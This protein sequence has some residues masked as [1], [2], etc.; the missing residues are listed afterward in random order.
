[1]LNQRG[2]LT[3]CPSSDT[4]WTWSGQALCSAT[5]KDR[6]VEGKAPQRELQQIK[7]PIRVLYGR[8]IK[9][10]DWEGDT[11]VFVVK[12]ALQKMSAAV[13]ASKNSTH[14]KAQLD[15]AS[16]NTWGI[17]DENPLQGLFT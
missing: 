17:K 14:R 10:E 5:L 3:G 16:W 8:I 13:T 4:A 2:V 11:A 15:V 6:D 9:A 1:M 7:G 12:S